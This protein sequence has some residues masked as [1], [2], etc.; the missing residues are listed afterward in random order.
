MTLETKKGTVMIFGCF[1]I[2]HPGH[3]F[4]FLEAKKYGDKL[5]AVVGRD[6]TI[7][8]IKGKN[9][10]YNEKERISM[11]S[12]I[13][14]IDKVILGDKIDMYKVIEDHK[15]DVICLGY[16]QIEF[17]DRLEEELNKRNLSTQIVRLDEYR[18]D[19]YKSSKI[20]AEMS[21]KIEK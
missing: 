6:K 13:D 9:S 20:K 7:K 19:I 18:S 1:D 21:R 12:K 15:P 10:L 4:F 2:I 8:N 16:D 5:I 17:I 3:L 11:L 14:V